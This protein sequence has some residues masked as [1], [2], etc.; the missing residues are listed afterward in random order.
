MPAV[1]TIKTV[2][3]KQIAKKVYYD[4]DNEKTADS[5]F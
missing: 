4:I 3:N 2:N 1:V 5:L